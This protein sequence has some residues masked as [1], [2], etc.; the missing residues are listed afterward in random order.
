[1]ENS[2]EKRSIKMAQL[3]NKKQS[4][5]AFSQILKVKYKEAE[6]SNSGAVIAYYFLLSLFPLLIVIGNLL[7][8]LNLSPETFY[9]YLENAIPSYLVESLKPIMNQILTSGSGGVLSIAAIGTLWSASRG[10]NA[11]QMSMNKAYGVNP[12]KNIIFVRLA[13]VTFTVILL[14]GLVLLV[15]VFSFG[16]LILEHLTPLLHLSASFMDT[17]LSIRWPV[18][19][20]TLFFAFSLLYYFVPNANLKLK[21]VLPGS[22]FSTVG[23]MLIT[24]AFTI[25][26]RYFARGTLSYGA[27]GTLIVF[28]LWLN[29]LGA[30]LTS[31]A[32]VNAAITE[33]KEGEIEQANSRIGNYV[34]RKLR[35]R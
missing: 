33:Y 27:I 29:V 35:R 3:T 12:R 16:Q 4:I 18:T 6:V 14:L 15:V 25:Y 2:N 9:P 10:M 24:Q 30:L 28:M 32:V 31:G 21:H 19:M 13:S 7:P 34:D 5:K 8:L 11:M 17:F 22:V 20:F 1:M 23:W 26:V